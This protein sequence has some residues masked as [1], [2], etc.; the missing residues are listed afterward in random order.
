MEWDDSEEDGR[1]SVAASAC[2]NFCWFFQLESTI[3]FE[4]VRRE[5]V[6]RLTEWMNESTRMNIEREN[7]FPIPKWNEERE[8]R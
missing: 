5:D 1:K 6:E 4:K 2:N 7:L 3:K 8:K